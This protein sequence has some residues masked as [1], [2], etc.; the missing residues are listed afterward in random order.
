MGPLTHLTIAPKIQENFEM[1]ESPNEVGNV[2]RL[3]GLERSAPGI[4]A[5]ANF[6]VPPADRFPF[7]SLRSTSK[8]LSRVIPEATG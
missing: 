5:I 3:R 2:I 6:V 8:R 7:V 4:P 1:G